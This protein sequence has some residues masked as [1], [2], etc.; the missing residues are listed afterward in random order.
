[1][2][3]SK[4]NAAIKKP[5][6]TMPPPAPAASAE[7]APAVAADKAPAASAENTPGA[8]KPSTDETPPASKPSVPAKEPAAAASAAKV[9]PKQAEGTAPPR[10][11]RKPT[12]ATS[13]AAEPND[14]QRSPGE[15]GAAETERRTRTVEI[16]R[17]PR[18]EWGYEWRDEGPVPYRRVQPY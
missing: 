13:A 5:T 18:R 12:K 7:K 11:H 3:A 2:T 6:I 17:I 10:P 8:P 16:E 15:R 1:P 4:Q 9:Q 14:K